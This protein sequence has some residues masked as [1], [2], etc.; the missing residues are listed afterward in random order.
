MSMCEQVLHSL[1]K[2]SRKR[3]ECAYL[4]AMCHF[5]LDTLTAAA[6]AADGDA[7]T[8]SAAASP[9][10]HDDGGNGNGDR[11]RA[12]QRRRR[13]TYD[14][15]LM[16]DRMFV[17]DRAAFACA[18]LNEFDLSDYVQT[19]A[20]S[21]SICGIIVTGLANDS[22]ANV[23]QQ[24]VDDTSDVQ[25]ASLLILRSTGF[26]PETGSGDAQ[27]MSRRM[28]WW[29]TEYR[30]LLNKWECFMQ[31]AQLDVDIGRRQRWWQAHL[32]GHKQTSAA[33]AGA[34]AASS[35]SPSPSI[36]GASPATSSSP[37]AA[38]RGRGPANAVTAS[39]ASSSMANTNP[40]LAKF[41]R[42]TYVAPKSVASP[43][44]LLRCHC[45]ASLPADP[46]MKHDQADWLRKQKPIL[47]NCPS[48]KKALPHC[49]V[50]R[51][52]LGILNP[53]LE[54]TRLQTLHK[55]KGGT[56]AASASAAGG[57]GANG[58]AGTAAGAGCAGGAG[59]ADGDGEVDRDSAFL[60]G[61]WVFFCQRCKHGGHANCI[62]SWFQHSQQ[63][64]CGVNGCSCPCYDV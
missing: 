33:G 50:C 10:H 29:L 19:L 5:L 23:L 57:S 25:T 22:G 11:N 21:S 24:Y 16:D 62:E 38:S 31:R 63:S 59:A 3:K 34:G 51:H 52:R 36:G 9:H 41:Q 4:M 7:D 49:Y 20:S 1:R 61:E 40:R 55:R 35:T 46:M 37:A 15:I 6:S 48:C 30:M 64:K 8:N 28:W 42:M 56:D 53:Q 12:G 2:I 32:M 14:D 13:R 43:H 58:N 27:W 44:V 26:V 18:Y 60:F 45:G 39:S 17:E 54:G 47:E